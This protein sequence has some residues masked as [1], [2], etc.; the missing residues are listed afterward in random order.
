LGEAALET[1]EHQS[2]G[3]KAGGQRHPWDEA[4]AH[5]A[6]GRV[7]VEGIDGEGRGGME[8]RGGAKKRKTRG[9]GEKQAG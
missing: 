9:L 7:R 4:T 2:N 6:G 8:G 5:V 1:A 3:D